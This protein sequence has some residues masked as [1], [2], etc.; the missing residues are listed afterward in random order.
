MDGFNTTTYLP[1]SVDFH[2]KTLNRSINDTSVFNHTNS[3]NG[4]LTLKTDTNII[5]P[6]QL[7]IQPQGPL[8]ND[9]FGHDLPNYNTAAIGESLSTSYE[10]PT[11]EQHFYNGYSDWGHVITHSERTILPDL[12]PYSFPSDIKNQSDVI[13]NKMIYRVHRGRIRTQLVF[14]CVYCSH[15]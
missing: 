7:N 11:E 3:P 8:T 13:Y 5:R 10:P 6:I 12:E 1:L 14:Y 2:P 4:I 15:L 9:Y